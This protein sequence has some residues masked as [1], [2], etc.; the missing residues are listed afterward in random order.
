MNER[1]QKLREKSLTTQETISIERA[2]LLTEFYSS[3]ES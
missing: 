3:S 1:I 2:K